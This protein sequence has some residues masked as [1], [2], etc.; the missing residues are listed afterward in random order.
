MLLNPLTAISPIDGRY[1]DKTDIL[2]PLCSEYGLFY[3]RVLIE[4]RWL[5]ALA[6]HSGIQEI[7]KFSPTTQQQ[8]NDIIKNFSLEDAERIKF[9]EKT[10]RHDI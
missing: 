4:I 9:L 1:S 8:L 5:Q 6:A 3:F 7:S 10:T 2:R